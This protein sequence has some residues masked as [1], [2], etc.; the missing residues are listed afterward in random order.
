MV[1]EDVSAGKLIALKGADVR[2]RFSEVVNGIKGAIDFLRNSL[3]V[4]TLDNL[5]YPA[6]LVPLTVFFAAPNGRSV[7]MT[8]TQRKSLIAWFWRS[9]FSRRFS[10]GVIRNLNRDIKE[11]VNLRKGEPSS[12]REHSSLRP[13]RL[14]FKPS[15]FHPRRTYEDLYSPPRAT[16]SAQLRF[17]G[18]NYTRRCPS[19]V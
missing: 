14:F 19:N 15:F 1:A 12:H 6:L 3:K 8:G 4:E 17:R 9:C 11:M 5:P 10:A 13:C 16:Q 2:D 7:K 18:A